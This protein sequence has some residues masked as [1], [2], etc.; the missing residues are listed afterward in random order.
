VGA[1]SGVGSEWRE[2]PHAQDGQAALECVYKEADCCL[3]DCHHL[4][5]GLGLRNK[6]CPF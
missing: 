1:T 5:H 3:L 2:Q 6:L 4:S